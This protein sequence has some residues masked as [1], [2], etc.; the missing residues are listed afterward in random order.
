MTQHVLSKVNTETINPNEILLSLL[1][2]TEKPKN[3]QDVDSDATPDFSLDGSFSNEVVNTIPA[4]T[5][6][7]KNDTDSDE[8]P[9]LSLDGSFSNEMVTNVPTNHQNVDIDDLT[10]DLSFSSNKLIN[11]VS[12]LSK[13]PKNDRDSDVTP[14]LSLDGNFRNE[15]VNIKPK[16][17]PKNILPKQLKSEKVKSSQS[18]LTFARKTFKN[19][20]TTKETNRNDLKHYYSVVKKANYT[21]S[22]REKC[23]V[24]ALEETGNDT[25]V[26][27]KKSE[28]R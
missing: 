9:D 26:Q 27:K 18:S 7:Q 5:N 28:K 21:K 24:K 22:V 13:Y 4:V 12:I 25:L 8:T 15:V 1:E 17:C 16:L 20:I 6:N 2:Y 3:N 14:N 11:T 23:S 10:S 19:K